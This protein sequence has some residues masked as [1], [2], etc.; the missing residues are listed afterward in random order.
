MSWSWW[1]DTP[2]PTCAKLIEVKDGGC[3]VPAEHVGRGILDALEL[4][5][6]GP[7]DLALLQAGG[8]ELAGALL[9][10]QPRNAQQL[11]SQLPLLAVGQLGGAG[12]ADQVP[13]ALG[14]CRVAGLVHQQALPAPHLLLVEELPPVVDAD[15]QDAD[16]CTRRPGIRNVIPQNPNDTPPQN[17]PLSINKY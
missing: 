10:L 8:K 9:Q 7:E 6:Q 2:L 16:I 17:P 5:G 11:L 4:V 13:R 14:H 12:E 3:L 15:I 1:I